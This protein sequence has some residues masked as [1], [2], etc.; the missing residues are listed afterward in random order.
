MFDKE[1]L[2]V[3]ADRM[4]LK[5][6]VVDECEIHG[7]LTDNLDPGALEEAVEEARENPPEGLGGSDAA[8]AVQ[9]RL[10]EIGDECPGCVRNAES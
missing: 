4:L 10:N 6:E 8:K 5:H 2:E 3:W 7:V 9:E 1:A